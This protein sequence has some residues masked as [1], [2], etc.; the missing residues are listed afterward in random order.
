MTILK[1]YGIDWLAI[2][3]S[4]IAIYLLGNKNRKGFW[5]FMFSNVCYFIIGFL[6]NSLALIIGSTIF[7]ITNFRG[8]VKWKT[9]SK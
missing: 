5:G 9:N 4:F 6:T 2:F 3:S 8:W 1:Y 7:F